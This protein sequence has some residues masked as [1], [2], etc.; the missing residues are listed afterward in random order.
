MKRPRLNCGG[1]TLIELLVVIAI[2]GI[3]IALLLPAVQEARE[4]AR[5]VK[6]AA[7][8]RQIGIALHNYHEGWG[9]FPPS[10]YWP[11]GSNIHACNNKNL[12]KNWLILILILPFMEQQGLYD[13]FDFSKSITDEV[14]SRPR[15]QGLPVLLCPSDSFNG[16]PYDGSNYGQGADWARCNYA[17][18]ASLGYMTADPGPGVGGGRCGADHGARNAAFGHSRGWKNNLLRGVMGAN[19]SVSTG[20]IADGTSNTILVGE[21]RAGVVPIDA[22]APGPCAEDAPT[23]SGRM[24]P[25]ATAT[26]PTPRRPAPTTCRTATIFAQQWAEPTCW[27]GWEW[28][29]PAA[30]APT[31]NRRPAV[32]TPAAS[33]SAWPMAASGG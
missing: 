14:N 27:H 12:N 21:I 1:F 29:V 8:L 20:G 15:S 26:D 28:D 18:N 17:A 22:E 16:V 7:N 13:E 2:I 33:T 10:S 19:T 5:R 25:W 3:L 30:P 9:A 31:T 32:C 6:C 24:G 4:E 23:P 11:S